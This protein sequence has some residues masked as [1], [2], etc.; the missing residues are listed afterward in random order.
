[1]LA[2]GSASH[3]GALGG[4]WTSNSD[5][6]A[7]V[8]SKQ[9]TFAVRDGA[10][11]AVPAFESTLIKS[12]WALLFVPSFAAVSADLK[13]VSYFGAAHR[14]SRPRDAP[15]LALSAFVRS[16]IG[17]TSRVVRA[18]GGVTDRPY[19]L[20]LAGATRTPRHAT[21][22][23]TKARG[24]SESSTPPRDAGLERP[25][26]SLLGR[27]TGGPSAR[28]VA[29]ARTRPGPRAS[30]G[31]WPLRPHSSSVG[32]VERTK[33][34]IARVYARSGTDASVLHQ[35]TTVGQHLARQ[36]LWVRRARWS[37][38]WTHTPA[39]L[40]LLQPRRAPVAEAEKVRRSR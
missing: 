7:V 8:S 9:R 13:H 3:A 2:P 10:R 22:I 31:V 17:N 28:R 19:L 5:N 38:A 26:D 20:P 15:A 23:F 18:K 32:C 35:H 12:N 21:Q 6:P 30:P 11:D 39:A 24:V 37:M 25:S 4:A 29:R 34:A 16:R 33:S 14:R 40:P 1:M 36:G 27:N